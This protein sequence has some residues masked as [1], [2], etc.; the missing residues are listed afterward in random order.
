MAATDSPHICRTLFFPPLKTSLRKSSDT[1]NFL[2]PRAS[3][4]ELDANGVW[5]STK[6]ILSN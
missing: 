2:L 5:S 4:W 6:L 1:P 3:N